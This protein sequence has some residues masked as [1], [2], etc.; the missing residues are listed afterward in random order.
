MKSCLTRHFGTSRFEL[1]TRQ[2]T[3]G[4]GLARMESPCFQICGTGVVERRSCLTSREQAHPGPGGCGPNQTIS[5]RAHLAAAERLRHGGLNLVCPP[6]ETGWRSDIGRIRHRAGHRRRRRADGV[7]AA[8]KS[9]T[10]NREL[11]SEL[12]FRRG[13]LKRPHCARS[14]RKLVNGSRCPVSVA[15]AR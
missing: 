15:S 11:A 13:A 6:A 12:V 9:V 7:M 14:I 5:D 10:A 2:L 1:G 3:V 8:T 4:F